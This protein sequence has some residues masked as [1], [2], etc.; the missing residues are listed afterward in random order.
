MAVN[1]EDYPDHV[2]VLEST[3]KASIPVK[4]DGDQP[5]EVEAP[6]EI[7]EDDA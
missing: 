7:P 1:V 3:V 6:R 2:G 5:N 4:D